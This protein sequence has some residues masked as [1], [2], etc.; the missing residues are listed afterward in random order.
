MVERI[1]QYP[2]VIK[3]LTDKDDRPLWSVMIPSYNCSN[4]LK[5]TLQSVLLQ[6]RDAAEMQIVVVDDCSTDANVEDIVKDIGKGRIRFFKQSQNVGSLRN[7]ET[8]INLSRGKLIHLLHGDDLVKPGFYSE[9]EDLFTKH[10]SIG[11]AFTGLSEIDEKG[12]VIEPSMQIQKYTGII[13]NWLLKIAKNQSLQV[14]S[15]VVKR[16]VYEELG[17]FYGVHYGED[18]EMWVRIAC[19]FPVAYSTKNLALYRVHS[20]NI[21]SRYLS[22]G[23]NIRDIK[24]VINIIQNYLPVEKRKEIKKIASRNFAHYFSKNAHKIYEVHGNKQVALK[25][26]HGALLLYFNKWILIS[27]IKLYVKALINYKNLT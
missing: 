14:C 12:N 25:Q 20:N 8:C 16:S 26:A 17:G 13:E 18:W 3:P 21:S 1:P 10:P 5:E 19:N 6:A 11:A 22:T 15:I 9:I 27:L 23:Q 4:Y 24:T 2:P 7:F